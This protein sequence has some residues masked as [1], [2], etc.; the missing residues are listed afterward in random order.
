MLQRENPFRHCVT[1]RLE[2]ASLCVLR[3]PQPKQD[4]QD[5]S[6]L[7]S[8]T[9]VVS[10]PVT[11][12]AQM[13][14]ERVLG[15][16]HVSSLSCRAI[17]LLA[18]MAA[19]AASTSVYAADAVD[20]P[21]TAPVAND[22]AAVLSWDSAYIGAHNG[23]GWATGKGLAGLPVTGSFPNG[24][25]A[26]VGGDLSYTGPIRTIAVVSSSEAT[27]QAVRA[28]ARWAGVQGPNVVR[29][30]HICKLGLMYEHRS[31]CLFH[32]NRCL[33]PSRSIGTGRVMAAF[34]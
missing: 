3:P 6:G 2:F 20:R 25:V 32:R 13:R 26:G 10:R 23:Y 15:C 7:P 4:H 9:E 17:L 19:L 8:E 30:E 27:S 5:F 18:G 33:M 28:R 22:A 21:P 29:E 24:F 14:F 16:G 34:G 31:A 1:Y 12:K 11:T